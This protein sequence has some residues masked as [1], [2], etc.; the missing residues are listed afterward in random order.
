[1]SD[2]ATFLAFILGFGFILVA[3]ARLGPST[4]TL[5]GGLFPPPAGRDWPTGIQEPDAPRFAVAHLDALRPSVEA[6]PTT[7]AVDPVSRVD[8][9]AGPSVSD[10]PSAG[11]DA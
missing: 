3:G 10:R 5:L 7:V 6:P 8:M 11:S 2:D 4:P 9:H 1:M